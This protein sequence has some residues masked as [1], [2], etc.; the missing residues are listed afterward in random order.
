METERDRVSDRYRNRWRQRIKETVKQKIKRE[1]ERERDNVKEIGREYRQSMKEAEK[2]AERVSETGQPRDTGRN[3]E[4]QRKRDKEPRRQTQNLRGQRNNR[5]RDRRALRGPWQGEASEAEEAEDSS[6]HCP[7]CV[8]GWCMRVSECFCTY[9][10]LQLT[11]GSGTCLSWCQAQPSLAE[12]EPFPG[13]QEPQFTFLWQQHKTSIMKS[14]SKYG[15]RC[16]FACRPD[17]AACPP[18]VYPWPVP[19][20]A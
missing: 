8:L 12:A 10:C 11:V 5:P 14:P 2:Q 15:L 6:V 9:I 7:C 18:H 19:A 16:A 3:R 1:S 20:A 4:S 17:G 13:S